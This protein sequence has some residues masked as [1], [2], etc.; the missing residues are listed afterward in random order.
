VQVYQF[1]EGAWIQL[2]GNIN[3]ANDGEILGYSVSLSA[4]G[5]IVAV[6]APNAPLGIGKARVYELNG[7]VWTQLG[8]DIVGEESGDFFGASVS[9]NN[10]G[11]I[12]AVGAQ[13]TTANGN[14]YS[15]RVKV[16]EFNAGGNWSQLGNSIDGEAAQDYSGK[17][18]SL[19]DAG[20]ILAIGA[21]GNDSN[22]N[23][24]SGR[25]RVFE[26]IEGAWSQLGSNINGENE[27][28]NLGDSVSLNGDGT[29][30]AVGSKQS[31]GPNGDNSGRVKVFQFIEGTWTQLGGNI[32]G[33]TAEEAFGESVSLTS[34]GHAFA[35]GAVH[36]DANI[37]MNAYNN[38]NTKVYR[39]LQQLQQPIFGSFIISSRGYSGSTFTFTIVPPTTNS[40]GIFTYF[41]SNPN[42]A[43]IQGNEITVRGAG[44]TTITASQSA[45]SEHASG[46]IDTVF[47]V[48]L[49]LILEI[50]E[51][52]QNTECNRRPTLSTNQLHNRGVLKNHETVYAV[53]KK[54]KA[55]TSRTHAHYKRLGKEH[56]FISTF[57][58]I[59]KK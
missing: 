22:G 50:P 54:N 39:L 52:I 41:S 44:D 21:Y 57:F 26:F 9:L 33:E 51:S 7:T 24:N 11:T 10:A 38:G 29:I 14:P 5:T 49:E 31:D 13:N 53:G 32:D 1:V 19:N 18:I 56:D 36:Y 27:G 30:I 28:D 15:G 58:G 43:T 40:T 55:S 46:T 48:Y 8:E 2:G 35:S 47:T 45:T 34:D 42:V 12:I 6:G 37:I 23:S 16:Y 17:S 20:T 3:G 25:V 4:S 59:C